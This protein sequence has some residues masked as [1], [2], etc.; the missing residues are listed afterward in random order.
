MVRLVGQVLYGFGCRI[1]NTG[2][3]AC[4]KQ[5]GH[6]IINAKVNVLMVHYGALLGNVHKTII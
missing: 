6:Y 1:M 4:H 2:A 5:N 3:G